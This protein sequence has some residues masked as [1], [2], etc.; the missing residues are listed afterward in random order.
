[1]DVNIESSWS[2]S[3]SLYTPDLSAEEGVTV[4]KTLFCKCKKMNDCAFNAYGIHV[5]CSLNLKKKKFFGVFFSK[6]NFRVAKDQMCD[7]HDVAEICLIHDIVFYQYC[8]HPFSFDI[9]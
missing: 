5:L 4:W 3:S 2:I 9:K 1:M 6:N 7:K 8:T